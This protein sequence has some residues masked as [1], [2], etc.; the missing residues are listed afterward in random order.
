MIFSTARHRV[1]NTIQIISK[2]TRLPRRAAK[3]AT[4]VLD[5]EG[6]ISFVF[7]CEEM[8]SESANIADCGRG[9]GGAGR[10]F[11]EDFNVPLE[12]FTLCPGLAGAGALDLTLEL[13]ISVC[14]ILFIISLTFEPGSGV[15]WCCL[16]SDCSTTS[17]LLELLLRNRGEGFGSVGGGGLG[18]GL[19]DVMSSLSG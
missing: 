13:P 18:G 5:G 9:G 16:A 2:L 6:F 15:G 10:V 19:I 3:E 7:G 8:L 14:D 17:L 12:G 1:S 4:F 11:L